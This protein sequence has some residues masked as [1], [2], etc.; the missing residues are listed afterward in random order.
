MIETAIRS[1]LQAQPAIAAIV[2]SNIYPVLLPEDSQLPALTFQIVGS[3]SYQG[4]TTHG[5]QRLRVQIDCW[6]KTYLS[7]V[8][9]RDA[10]STSLDGY[11]DSNFSAL[12]LSK[13]D[14]YEDAA[15]MFRALLEFYI[16]TTS[17]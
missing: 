5:M 2:G 3:T 9:L 14:Y 6:A 13:V 7:A 1:V 4:L 12:L 10:I 15:L 8:T 17:V 16:F 11:K